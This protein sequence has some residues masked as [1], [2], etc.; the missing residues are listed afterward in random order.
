MAKEI[1][2]QAK[3]DAFV[4]KEAL[5]LIKDNGG[6]MRFSDIKEELPKRVVFSEKEMAPTKTWKHLWHSALGMVGGIELKAA[7]LLD[8]NKG[9]WTLTKK[10][11]EA[12]SLSD[13]EFYHLYHDNWLR[14]YKERKKKENQISSTAPKITPEISVEE[15]AEYDISTIESK[16]R[17]G[18]R[19]HIITKDPYQ[20]QDFVAALLKGMGY[21]VPYVAPKGRDGGIDIIAYQ[22][23]LGCNG[24]H[25]K[26]Q[27]KHYP[28]ST[29]S[30]D[31]V[32][33]LAGVLHKD[34][35]IGIV[36]TSG[37]FT[38][39]C[40]KEARM[41]HRHVRLLDIDD[42]IDM[43]IEYYPNFKEEI[44]NELPLKSIYFLNTDEL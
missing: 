32:R 19:Q 20:F 5:Y 11:E 10:G 16:A 38:Q 2:E 23:P 9:V 12:L 17:E 42:L 22:D 35:E 13:E 27:V 28:H 25:I 26:V 6:Q 40:Y 4:L 15:I 33:N 24:S 36:A 18:I 37:K 41:S 30:V 31:I 8:T 3:R 44:K 43:W 1:S 29:I 7:G 39:D 34:N 14:L 21:H